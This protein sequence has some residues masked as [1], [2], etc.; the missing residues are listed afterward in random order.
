MAVSVITNA[1]EKDAW[2]YVSSDIRY[3][4]IHKGRIKLE[5][6]TDKF[7]WQCFS[8]VPANQN[9]ALFVAM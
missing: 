3:I 7:S 5:K 6:S 2:K 8:Y 9:A 4:I 1:N